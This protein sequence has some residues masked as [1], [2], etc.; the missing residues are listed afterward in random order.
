MSY[1]VH[2]WFTVL[3]FSSLK[4]KLYTRKAKQQKSLLFPYFHTLFKVV[5]SSIQV[6]RALITFQCFHIKCSSLFNIYVCASKHYVKWVNEGTFFFLLFYSFSTWHLQLIRLLR[7]EGSYPTTMETRLGDS[8]IWMVKSSNNIMSWT[9]YIH[10][11]EFCFPPVFQGENSCQVLIQRNEV[12]CRQSVII[13][14]NERKTLLVNFWYFFGK[15]YKNWRKMPNF[16]F[17]T[18]IFLA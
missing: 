5:F 7:K 6:S 4:I 11:F 2:F 9:K 3:F 8:L 14:P 18:K 1:F 17:K 13:F 10:F 15:W 16:S 12:K